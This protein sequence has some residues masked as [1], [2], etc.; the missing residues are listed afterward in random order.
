MEEEAISKRRKNLKA[1]KQY[2]ASE[3]YHKKFWINLVMRRPNM[4]WDYV[5]SLDDFDLEFARKDERGTHSVE[6]E[7]PLREKLKE[8]RLNDLGAYVDATVH[9]TNGHTGWKEYLS[10]DRVFNME[11]ITE[12]VEEN[13][14]EWQWLERL[15]QEARKLKKEYETKGRNGIDFI[16]GFLGG[17]IEKRRVELAERIREETMEQ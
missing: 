12:G 3:Y 16:F 5:F 8:K 11:K 17:L 2:L 15:S 7:G 1:Q 9:L 13:N 10:E 6:F 4:L 14:W